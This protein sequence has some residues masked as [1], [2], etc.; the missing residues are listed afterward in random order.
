MTRSAAI[1][2]IPTSFEPRNVGSSF[3]IEP[4]LG[5]D[6]KIIDL[7]FAPEITYHVGNRVWAEWKGEHGNSPIQMPTFYVLRLSTSVTLADGQ[8]MFVAALSPKK[9]DGTVDYTRKLMV[10]VKADVITV[11]R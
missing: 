8:P 5:Y 6:N 10:F 1:G 7:R 2:P 4:T 3:E 11:G 9:Q